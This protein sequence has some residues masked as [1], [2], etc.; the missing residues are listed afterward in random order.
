MPGRV[1]H[2]RHAQRIR[3]DRRRPP[4]RLVRLPAAA[5]HDLRRSGRRRHP[6]RHLRDRAPHRERLRT[7]DPP[8]RTDLDADRPCRPR[9]ARR[10][11]SRASCAA[12]A[13]AGVRRVAGVLGDGPPGRP[14]A[15]GG[16]RADVERPR[17]LPVDS[18]ELER[19]HAT[20]RAQRPLA[21]QRELVHLERGEARGGVP[22]PEQR[23]EEWECESAEHAGK[24]RVT[25]HAFSGKRRA[26][27]LTECL[28]GRASG[29]RLRDADTFET[30]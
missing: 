4:D 18:D 9:P 21:V 27:S 7:T 13:L 23:D 5:R 29:D 20:A 10:G 30:S 15:V 1:V 17:P 2:E 25:E 26:P 12:S 11:A 19:R 24:T 14:A 28:P 6:E 16:L 22:R 3:V 8:V